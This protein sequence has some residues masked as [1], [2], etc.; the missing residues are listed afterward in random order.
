MS[1]ALSLCE[2]LQGNKGLH[3]SSFEKGTQG[4]FHRCWV[5]HEL[6]LYIKGKIRNR[7]ETSVTNLFYG[8]STLCTPVMR[9]KV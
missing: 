5:T 1:D 4:G 2:T 6:P 8:A 7:K 9:L 3:S